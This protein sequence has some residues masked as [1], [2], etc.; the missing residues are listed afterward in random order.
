MEI[1]NLNNSREKSAEMFE[2]IEWNDRSSV[3]SKDMPKKRGKIAIRWLI[4]N[5]DTNWIT[6]GYVFIF[7]NKSHFLVL[8]LC[9][10]WLIMQRKW[11]WNFSNIPD[12]VYLFEDDA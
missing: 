9:C 12:F 3:D 5:P 1:L 10:L 2:R 7:E 8:F 11:L 6:L 4:K